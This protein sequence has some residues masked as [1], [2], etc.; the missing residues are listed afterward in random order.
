MI[1][2]DIIPWAMLTGIFVGIALFGAVLNVLKHWQGFVLWIIADAGL[3]A[4]NFAGGEFAQGILWCAYTGLATW[5]LVSWR[6]HPPK[7]R[8]KHG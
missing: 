4:V 6:R 2:W 5:G 3:A 8:G 1:T 7:I